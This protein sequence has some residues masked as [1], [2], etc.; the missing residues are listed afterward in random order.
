MGYFTLDN[1]LIKTTEEA[2]KLVTYRLSGFLWALESRKRAAAAVTAP[3]SGHGGYTISA[4]VDSA[5]DYLTLNEEL[6]I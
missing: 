1:G 5:R 6:K 2:R 3:E 4:L